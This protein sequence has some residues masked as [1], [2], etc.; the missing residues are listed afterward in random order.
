M[1]TVMRSGGKE[2]LERESHVQTCRSIIFAITSDISNC[3][4]ILRRTVG[5]T[6]SLSDFILYIYIHRRLMSRSHSIV[7][8]LHISAFMCMRITPDCERASKTQRLPKRNPNSCHASYRV[9]ARITK[10]RLR[11]N[12]HSSERLD[13]RLGF[14][15]FFS[16]FV[17]EI[18]E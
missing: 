2:G 10:M 13:A 5:E 3:R 8:H 7:I 1:G 17:S 16:I 6:L 18:I 14:D 11:L 15:F 4:V 12:F 9:S